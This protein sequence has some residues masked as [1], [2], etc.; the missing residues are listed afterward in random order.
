MN[1]SKARKCGLIFTFSTI[2]LYFILLGLLGEEGFLHARS[3][4]RDLEHL[5]QRQE[6]LVLQVDSLE[7]Q[8]TL[9][10][11]QDALKDAAFRF[12]YQA[13]GEQVFYFTDDG[14]GEYG[15]QEEDTISKMESQTFS[16]FSKPWIALL[17]LAFSA[18]FTIVWAVGTQRRDRHR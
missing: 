8:N 6:A 3:I 2:L 4:R 18:I 10:S 14:D 16:G 15:H 1:K 13:E 7:Q 12:G 5:R 11:S 9:M 17:S